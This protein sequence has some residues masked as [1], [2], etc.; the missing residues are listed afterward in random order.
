MN[1]SVQTAEMSI[2]KGDHT[3]SKATV[4]LARVYFGIANLEGAGAASQQRNMLSPNQNSTPEADVT[5][6]ITNY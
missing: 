4:H 1:F 6:P 5:F 2:T 3:I